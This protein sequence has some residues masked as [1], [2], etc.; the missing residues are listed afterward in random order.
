MCSSSEI[1]QVAQKKYSKF[2]TYQGIDTI[3]NER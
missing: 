3:I 1:M 2:F